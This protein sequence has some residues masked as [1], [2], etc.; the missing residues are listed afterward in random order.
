MV[1]FFLYGFEMVD[2]FW[3]PFEELAIYAIETFWVTGFTE[4]R[5]ILCTIIFVMGF[6]YC[7]CMF[8]YHSLCISSFISKTWAILRSVSSTTFYTL[9]YIKTIAFSVTKSLEIFV[10]W[11]FWLYY[12]TRVSI[13]ISNVIRG[14]SYPTGQLR[15]FFFLS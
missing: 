13:K 1:N 6:F 10:L 2:P 4:F 14:S 5:C 3:F 15:S 11:H 9:W 8:L 7:T 12:Y